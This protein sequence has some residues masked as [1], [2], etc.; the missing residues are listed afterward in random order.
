[1]YGKR[2]ESDDRLLRCTKEWIEHWKKQAAEER[3]HNLVFYGFVDNCLVGSYYRAFDVVILPFSQNVRIGKNK[4]ANIGK[5]IS[6]LKLFEAMAY[7]KPILVSRLATIEEVMEDGKDCIVAEP[8]NIEDW[9][10]KLVKLCKDP[11]MQKKLGNAAQEK[12][13][14]EYTWLERARKAAQ[15]FE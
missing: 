8:D 3:L 12:L 6:P 11:E 5:W 13:L 4:R 1:M 15:L 14:R 7:G 9:A 10:E 2:H